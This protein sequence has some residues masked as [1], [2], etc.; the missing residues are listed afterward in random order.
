MTSERRAE[1][2]LS[3]ARR[4]I[5]EMNDASWVRAGRIG[6]HPLRKGCNCI[7]CVNMRKRLI[8]KQTRKWRYRL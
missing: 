2:S 6:K 4:A 1:Q 3:E 7:V 5:L 8:F